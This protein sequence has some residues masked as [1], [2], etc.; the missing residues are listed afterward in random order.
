MSMCI[1]SYGYESRM[2][3]AGIPDVRIGGTN[4]PISAFAGGGA[5]VGAGLNPLAGQGKAQEKTAKE[6]VE[7]R[8]K[9]LSAHMH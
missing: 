9:I 2:R 5:A 7:M 8:T 1:K 4:A 6:L 3:P